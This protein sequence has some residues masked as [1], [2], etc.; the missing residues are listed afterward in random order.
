MLV[1]SQKTPQVPNFFDLEKA[2]PI[3]H[4]RN[5]RIE[6]GP[7]RLGILHGSEISVVLG[8]EEC[9]GRL[10]SARRTGRYLVRIVEVDQT[11]G[12]HI[13]RVEGGV[14]GDGGKVALGLSEPQHRSIGPCELISVDRW[15]H[16][17]CRPYC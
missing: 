8:L 10:G 13:E 11:I 17:A 7:E 5:R 9:P 12:I 16:L 2:D 4:S 3:E 14:V 15:G 6:H 1:R